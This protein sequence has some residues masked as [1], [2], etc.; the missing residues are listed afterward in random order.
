MA[1][2]K[3]QLRH[4]FPLAANLPTAFPASGEQSGAALPNVALVHLLCVSH[5]D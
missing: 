1:K 2:E 5:P 4:L 3:S